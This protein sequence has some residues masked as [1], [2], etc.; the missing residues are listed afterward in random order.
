MATAPQA[1]MDMPP[2]AANPYANPFLH[3]ELV[4]KFNNQ[5]AILGH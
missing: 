5:N 1:A 4:S 2:E 3:L